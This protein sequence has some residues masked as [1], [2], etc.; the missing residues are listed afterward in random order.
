MLT[1][2]PSKNGESLTRRRFNRGKKIKTLPAN[3]VWEGRP[4]IVL[5]IGKLNKLLL[6][7]IV[8]FIVGW[9]TNWTYPAWLIAASLGLGAYSVVTWLAKV[10]TIL[11]IRYTIT[12]ERL[13]YRRGVFNQVTDELEFFRVRDFQVQKPFNLRI[14]GLGNVVLVTSDRTHPVVT[15]FAIPETEKLHS[16]IRDLVRRCWQSRGVYEVDSG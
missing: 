6:A 13:L 12:Y 14:L 10:V 11:C 9:N 7:I 3:V 15:L 5:A 2:P 1:L 4:S 8:M 16:T